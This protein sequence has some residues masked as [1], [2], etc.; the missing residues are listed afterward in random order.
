MGVIVEHEIKKV[1]SVLLLLKGA[2]WQ[3]E[4]TTE[5]QYF[6]YTLMML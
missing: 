2:N 5:L 1:R 6:V 3:L 4:T